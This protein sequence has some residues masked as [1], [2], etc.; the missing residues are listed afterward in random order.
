MPDVQFLDVYAID[1]A[2]GGQR[3]GRFDYQGV[4]PDLG[5]KAYFEKPITFDALLSRLADLLHARRTERRGEV[6][7]R[8]RVNLRLKGSDED[9]KAFSEASTTENLALSSFFCGCT[10]KLKKDSAIEVFMV[11]GEEQ[12]AGHARAVRAE[13]TET[14]YPRYAFAF[15][16]RPEDWALR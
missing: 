13:A 8:L 7:V 2:C 9:G 5:A 16:E 12:F 6:R 11:R 14:P 3:R 15:I 4:V 10:A 1:T